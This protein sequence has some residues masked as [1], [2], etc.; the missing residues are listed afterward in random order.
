MWTQSPGG[1]SE[2]VSHRG[3]RW[4]RARRRALLT[5]SELPGG[6][7]SGLGPIRGSGL[8]AGPQQQEACWSSLSSQGATVWLLQILGAK[9]PGAGG[10]SA[11]CWLCPKGCSRWGLGEGLGQLL[12]KS[13][14][15]EAVPRITPVAPLSQE[16]DGKLS[17][18]PWK[19][20][21]TPGLPRSS[22]NQ[23]PSGGPKRVPWCG[24]GRGPAA[25]HPG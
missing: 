15:G 12:S 9:T 7:P 19:P 17:T 2:G 5:K 6:A 4:S 11:P 20:E 18:L 14:P 8:E 22:P 24:A 3:L 1:L 25:P 10:N 13:C 21:I 23:G 16:E